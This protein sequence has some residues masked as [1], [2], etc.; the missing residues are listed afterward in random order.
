ME[1]YVL[2]LR[3]I[4]TYDDC[5]NSLINWTHSSVGLIDHKVIVADLVVEELTTIR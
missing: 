3:R 2:L 4:T 1:H 5:L